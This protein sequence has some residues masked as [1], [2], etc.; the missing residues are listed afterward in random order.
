[1]P[2]SNPSRQY[3]SKML[4]PSIFS[5][6][7][8]S[9]GRARARA[10]L[11]DFLPSALLPLFYIMLYAYGS[12]PCALLTSSPPGI[13]IRKRICARDPGAIP[14]RARNDRRNAETLGLRQMLDR[15]NPNFITAKKETAARYNSDAARQVRT[16]MSIGRTAERMIKGKRDTRKKNLSSCN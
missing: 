3:T 13:P 4:P 10:S 11:S 9:N 5:R 1:M 8:E 12:P 7:E 6:G 2:Y 15:A 16:P 14:P